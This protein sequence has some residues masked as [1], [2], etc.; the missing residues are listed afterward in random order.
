VKSR[1]AEDRLISKV[2]FECQILFRRRE[3][4]GIS[5]MEKELGRTISHSTYY[6]YLKYINDEPELLD[7]LQDQARVGFVKNQRDMVE[8]TILLKQKALS[9][10][11]KEMAKTDDE[12]TR[13]NQYIISLM[14][15][16]NEYNKRL[17]E[18]NLGN[19]VIAT[20]KYMIDNANKPKQRLEVATK[21][22]H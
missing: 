2:A 18:L 9:E 20:I 7:W 11:D 15:M 12:E 4:E 22:N 3:K 6:N 1:T 13:N 8:E 5:H 19:P 16:I 14:H 21:P 10:L 17:G